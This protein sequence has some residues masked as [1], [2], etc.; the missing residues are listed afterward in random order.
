MAQ[1]PSR[2][3]IQ[4]THFDYEDDGPTLEEPES[5]E[6]LPLVNVE[7]PQKTTKN[8]I[9][10]THFENDEATFEE[11]DL[12]KTLTPDISTQSQ[13]RAKTFNNI[14][15]FGNDTISAHDLTTITSSLASNTLR[16]PA[17]YLFGKSMNSLFFKQPVEFLNTTENR[18]LFSI[19]ATDSLPPTIDVPQKLDLAP[20]ESL[21]PSSIT[22]TPSPSQ[23]AADLLPPTIDVP[24]KLDLAPAESL[25]PSSITN[26]PYPSQNAADLLPPTIDVPQK[27]DPAP[28]ESF[29]PSSITNTK[30]VAKCRRFVATNKRCTSKT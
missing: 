11:P 21:N 25:N 3:F 1:K 2:N 14:K 30:S 4:I 28:A 10:L 5:F 27:L 15:L 17:I 19:K 18:K 24:Q 23:N 16:P 8:F 6:K 26:T 20:A 12:S 22:N 13:N 9:Q 29:N 7:Q